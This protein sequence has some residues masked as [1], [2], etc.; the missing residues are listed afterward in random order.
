MVAGG[1]GGGPAVW[2][3]AP[4][5]TP[6]VVL[7]CRGDGGR[8]ERGLGRGGAA[9]VHDGGGGAGGDAAGC[10]LERLT[11]LGFVVAVSV[12]VGGDA[13]G[14]DGVQR[15]LVGGGPGGCG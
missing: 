2:P 15:G 8:G 4:G 14:G 6:G 5:S 7:G 1:R 9:D 13:G 10:V 3:G 12:P 11:G